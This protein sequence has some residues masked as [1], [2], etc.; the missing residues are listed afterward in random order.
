MEV[1]KLAKYLEKIFFPPNMLSIGGIIVLTYLNW[2]LA[3]VLAFFLPLITTIILLITLRN[4]IED[5]NN[6]YALS[7]GP[8]LLLFLI[9]FGFF[10]L[11]T[12]I[13]FGIISMFLLLTIG[14]LIRPKWKISGHTGASTAVAMVLSLIDPIFLPLF[15]IVPIVG[16]ARL[17]LEA[18]TVAQVLAG[19]LLGMIVPSILYIVWF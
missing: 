19:F 1:E 10:N 12:E 9:L 5:E 14:Y 3:D 7:A 4:K 11:S 6:L 13:V 2:R 8:N 15:I 18:H 17:E 16:W